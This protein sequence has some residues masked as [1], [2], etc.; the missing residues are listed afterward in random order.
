M[1]QW[2]FVTGAD[3]GVGLSLVKGL[4]EKGYHV[5][6]GQYAGAEAGG[7]LERLEE[8]NE[9]RLKRVPLDISN[10]ASVREALEAVAAATDRLDILINNGAILGD[11]QA[12][13]EDELD[14]EEM[15]QVFRVNALGALRISNGLIRP[16]LKS[17]SKLIVNISSEAGSIGSCWRNA[18]YAYCMSKAALNMQSQLIHNQIAP[19]GG[20]VMVI[21]PGHVQTYMQGKLDTAGRLTPDESAG[22]ILKLVEQRLDP[23][24]TGEG[25]A[26]IDYAGE[27]LPW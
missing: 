26:L 8:L 24:Y 20:K 5:F 19:K 6:A 2:A 22:G 23:G 10:A 4:L 17:G 14:F 13:I 3:R 21:H 27:T 25:L 11:M 15:D 9:G 7:E 12:T 18:W 1:I 16:I